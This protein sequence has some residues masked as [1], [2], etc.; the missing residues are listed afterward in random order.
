MEPTPPEEL[1]SNPVFISHQKHMS[2]F[3]TSNWSFCSFPGLKIT[4]WKWYQPS[5]LLLGPQPKPAFAWPSHHVALWEVTFDGSAGSQV[6]TERA[7]GASSSW[8]RKQLSLGRTSKTNSTYG[9]ELTGQQRAAHTHTHTPLF[10][11]RR[12]S[13]DHHTHALTLTWH[14]TH[15]LTNCICVLFLIFAWLFLWFSDYEV[16][17]KVKGLNPEVDICVIHYLVTIS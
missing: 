4:R 13:H 3:Q 10:P 2:G 14:W 8:G 15:R 16:E 6:P 11:P 17:L 12:R 1:A 7:D 5:P 9:V